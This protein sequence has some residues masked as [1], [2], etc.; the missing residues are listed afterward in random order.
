M[1]GIKVFNNLVALREEWYYAVVLLTL[2]F[3]QSMRIYSYS[4]LH[5][6]S[7]IPCY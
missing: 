4:V 1:Y 5:S 6:S 2:F 7:V 3:N